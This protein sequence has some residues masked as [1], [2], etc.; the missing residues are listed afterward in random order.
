MRKK[1]IFDSILNIIAAAVPLVILQLVVLPLLG[2]KLGDKEYGLIITLI[3]L[4]TLFSFPFGIVLNNVRLL[5]DKDYHLGNLDGDFNFLLIVSSIISSILVIV[6]TVYYEKDFSFINIILMVV[7]SCLNLFREYM[8]VSFRLKLNYKSIL[9]NNILLGIGYIIGTGIFYITSYWHFIY[10][11]GSGISLIYIMKNSNLL[12]ESYGVTEKFKSTLYKSFILYCSSFLK[13]L[14]SYADK[15]L[16]FPL[17]G[18][19]AVA[20]YYTANILGKIISMVIN[21]VSSVILSYLSSENNGIFKFKSFVVIISIISFVGYFVTII[22]S[23]PIL[24]LLYPNWASESFKLIYI[25]TASTIIE[26][27]CSIIH[28]FILKYNNINWQIVIST[29][30]LIVYVVCA[31]LFYYSSGL[32]GFCFGI[33]IATIIKLILMAIIFILNQSPII[34]KKHRKA[35][36]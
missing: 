26:I 20:I 14:V 30:N 12:K 5:L 11:V 21:P 33:L 35:D 6:G 32:K 9:I 8:L 29:A 7:I 31:M 19:E 27:I 18:P 22:I 28:P 23:K 16:L 24:D 34:T 25:T 10:I 17:L 2:V 1:F 13:T 15:L 36:F 3:S 4:F